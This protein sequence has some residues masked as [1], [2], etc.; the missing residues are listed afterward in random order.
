MWLSNTNTNSYM[1]NA[2]VLLNFT[3][4]VNEKSIQAILWDAAIIWFFLVKFANIPVRTP[5]YIWRVG[6]SAVAQV[7][8]V[9]KGAWV[10]IY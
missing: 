1:M 8:V 4:N 3:M 2:A 10:C 6:F 9:D 7:F 5:S